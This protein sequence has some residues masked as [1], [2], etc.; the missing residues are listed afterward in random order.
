LVEY[1][2]KKVLAIEVPSSSHVHRRAGVVYDRGHDGDFRVQDLPRIA[3]LVNKKQ[4]YHTEQVVYPWLKVSDFEP[5]I[6][7]KARREIK[8]FYPKHPW[9]RLSNKA[10]LMRAGL[11]RAA[12]TTLTDMT[13]G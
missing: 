8:V 2:G 10:V 12:G 6:L 1:D 5:G 13:T 7:A 3:A 9:L 11:W 4:G